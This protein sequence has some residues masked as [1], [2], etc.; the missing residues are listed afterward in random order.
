M[1]MP[2]TVLGQPLTDLSAPKTRALVICLIDVDDFEVSRLAQGDAWAGEQLAV[3]EQLLTVVRERRAD[4][5]FVTFVPS[6]AWILAIGGNDP[7][8]L[9]RIAKTE[10]EEIRAYVARASEVT[11]TI[12]VSRPH[13]GATRMELALGEAV[14][15]IERKLLETGDRVVIYEPPP[16]RMASPVPQRLRIEDELARAIRDGD[17]E[18]AF[19]VLAAWIDRIAE[20]EGATP[21][22]LRRWVSAEMMYA[23]DVSNRQRL[24]D[25]SVDW[26]DALSRLSL[27]E[28][29][30]MSG[31]H[32]RSYLMLWLQRLLERIVD[33]PARNAAGRHVLALVEDYIRAHSAED[34]H[35]ADVAAAVFVSPY[36][37]SHLFQR[38]KG[39]T[40]LRYLTA[41]RMQ[42]GREL[43]ATTNIP[44]QIIAGQVGYTSAKRFAMLFKRT[45][46]VTPSEFRAQHSR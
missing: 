32:D 16:S 15:G 8:A 35:L 6:D 10:A 17:V 43:L 23:L 7:Q 22:V 30:A 39:T 38:E 9:A 44:V 26:F 13:F 28:L 37:I 18:M 33:V 21:D 34:L 31:I 20:A 3:V 25:G 46:K 40:F 2:T 4:D 19:K 24:A 12:G 1:S 27:E 29:V 14:A 5:T 41:V 42:K 36:Y 11:V 45:F